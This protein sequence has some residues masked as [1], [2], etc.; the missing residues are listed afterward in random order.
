MSEPLDQDLWEKIKNEI[1]SRTDKRWNAYYSGQLVKEYK[2][3]GGK[4]KTVKK[5]IK[6]LKRWFD[7]KWT[8]IGGK[9]YPVYRPT[10]RIN[11]DTPLLKSEIDPKNLRKQIILKQN[12]KGTSNLKPFKKKI[13]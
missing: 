9:K 1:K 13:I 7:E 5:G 12:I 6:P 3:R 10:K 8:D 2:K 4:F 11:K